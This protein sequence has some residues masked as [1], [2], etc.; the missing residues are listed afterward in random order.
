M[1]ARAAA[2]IWE[3]VLDSTCGSSTDFG[4]SCNYLGEVEQTAGDD[5]TCPAKND[6]MW[7]MRDNVCQ[8]SNTRI[9]C[10]QPSSVDTSDLLVLASFDPKPTSS[11]P[12]TEKLFVVSDQSCDA[13][14]LFDLGESQCE[15]AGSAIAQS[16]YLLQSG[17][18][19]YS[20]IASNFAKGEKVTMFDESWSAPTGCSVMPNGVQAQAGAIYTNLT[21]GTHFRTPA[22]GSTCDDGQLVYRSAGLDRLC[23]GDA[24]ALTHTPKIRQFVERR[25]RLITITQK[26]Y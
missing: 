22:S 13:A 5:S 24:G 4:S 6:G 18:Q 10:K 15:N 14:G 25:F 16:D 11:P 12:D 8:N 21:W 3:M 26:L 7:H 20:D 23:V 19:L 9:V 2:S 17:K 1:A